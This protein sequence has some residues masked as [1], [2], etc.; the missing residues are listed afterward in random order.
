MH[1]AIPIEIMLRGN[2]RVFTENIDHPVEPASGR[3]PTPRPC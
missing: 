3:R 2:N 1:H